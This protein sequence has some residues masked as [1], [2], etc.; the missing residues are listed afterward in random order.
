MVIVLPKIYQGP[1]QKK[2]LASL[3]T[4]AADTQ[5]TAWTWGTEDVK[6]FF[7]MKGSDVPP[8]FKEF[9]WISLN[10]YECLWGLKY[11]RGIMG[12]QVVNCNFLSRDFEADSL[13]TKTSHDG[14]MGIHSYH[15]YHL[16]SAIGGDSGI[17][18]MAHIHGSNGFVSKLCLYNYCEFLN[19]VITR[20]VPCNRICKI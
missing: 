11:H 13:G 1:I 18:I 19:T 15:G 4:D 8:E 3:L 16:A 7:G 20:H 12:V 5:E 2:C 14:M 6:P 17:A 10:I 9:H